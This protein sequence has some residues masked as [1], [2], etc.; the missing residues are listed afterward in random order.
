MQ[1]QLMILDIMVND[2]CDAPVI[3]RVFGVDV[4][5]QQV[6][7]LLGIVCLLID[8]LLPCAQEV[9]TSHVK[10]ASTAGRHRLPINLEIAAHDI[11]CWSGRRSSPDASLTSSSW[12]R[13][14]LQR[15]GSS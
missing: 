5:V 9:S 11:S 7:R 2:L 8:F 4:D 6:E 14:M 15:R 3:D 13:T 1:L 12:S 10:D